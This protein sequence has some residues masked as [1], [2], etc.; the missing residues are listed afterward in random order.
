MFRVLNQ[1][2]PCHLTDSIKHLLH[3]AGHFVQHLMIGSD[4]ALDSFQNILSESCPNLYNLAIHLPSEWDEVKSN[5]LLHVLQG[6]QRLMRLSLGILCTSYADILICPSVFP[7]LTHLQLLLPSGDFDSTSWENWDV[8]AQFP[9]LTHVSVP[10]TFQSQEDFL[11]LLQDWSSLQLLVVIPWI[12]P[13]SL[14]ASKFAGWRRRHFPNNNMK[15]NRLVM[16]AKLDFF[17]AILDWEKGA[18]GGV[19]VWCFAELVVF[20]RESEYLVFNIYVTP[21]DVE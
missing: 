14:S 9:M 12:S 11:K 18:N 6:M 7:N 3:S 2:W 17:P 21:F 19:D 20:A 13:L 1:I 4:S 15:D 5:N 8:F 16:L 10:A